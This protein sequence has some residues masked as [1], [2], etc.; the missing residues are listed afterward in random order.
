MEKMYQDYKDIVDFQLVYIK[1]AHAA[2]SNWSVDYAKD[3]GITEHDNHL[4]RCTAADMLFKDKALSIPFLVDDM[5][6]AVNGAYK[7]F[8]D[9][10]FLVRKDGRLAVAATRGPWGFSP[11]LTQVATWLA[12]YR[13]NGKEPDLPKDAK[14]A[15]EDV[16]VVTK[17]EKRADSTDKAATKSADGEDG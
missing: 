7:A 17:L 9:R 8:P 11:A 15:G 4:E 14:E 5:K 13:K 2:D 1:E 6:D 16:R 12:E 10:I 3:L